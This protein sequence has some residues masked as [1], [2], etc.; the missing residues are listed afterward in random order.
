MWRYCAS[1]ADSHKNVYY[2]RLKDASSW[3]AW[4]NFMNHWQSSNNALN[5]HFYLYGSEED[6]ARDTNRW[7]FCN[8]NDGGVGF[9]RDCGPTGSVGAQWN[10]YSRSGYRP[11]VWWIAVVPHIAAPTL[12]IPTT[13]DSPLAAF[14]SRDFTVEM[15]LE[16]FGADIS[17]DGS[18]GC[19]FTRTLPNRPD[20][21]HGPAVFLY[22][23]GFVMF[24]MNNDNGQRAYCGGVLPD[25]HVRGTRHLTFI[26]KGLVLMILVDH[27]LVCQ[28]TIS[29]GDG[30]ALHQYADANLNFGRHTDLPNEQNLNVN[31]RN[32]RITEQNECSPCPAGT[33]KPLVGFLPCIPC[34][35]GTYRDAASAAT[36]C[37]PCPLNTHAPVE[38]L[39]A[40]L[41]ATDPCPSAGEYAND[42]GVCTPCPAN[43]EFSTANG[44][45]TNASAC[46][47]LAGYSGQLGGPCVPCNHYTYKDTVGS[48]PCTQCHDWEYSDKAA[49]ARSECSCKAGYTL[50]DDN[51]LGR[52]GTNC[53]LC[54]KGKFKAQNGPEPC[55]DCPAGTYSD[56]YPSTSCLDCPPGTTSWPGTHDRHGC[57]C[58]LRGHVLVDGVCQACP[59][60]H[61]CWGGNHS[62]PCPLNTTSPP[63]SHSIANCTPDFEN[64]EGI[65][66]GVTPFWAMQCE[67]T[68]PCPEAKP[69]ED[70]SGAGV[71]IHF[72]PGYGEFR[73]YNFSVTEPTRAKIAV[74]GGGGSGGGFRR[75]GGQG[76]GGAGDYLHD[77]LMLYPGVNYYFSVGAGGKGRA[78]AGQDVAKEDDGRPTLVYAND[79][80]LYYAAP[81]DAPLKNEDG[82]S[83]IANGGRW[84]GRGS[85]EGRG[86]PGRTMGI[87]G[88]PLPVSA[89]GGCGDDWADL[90][91]EG[92]G[93]DVFLDTWPLQPPVRTGGDGA[94]N[95]SVDGGDAR[96]LG[97][98]GGGLSWESASYIDYLRPGHGGD[99]AVILR[100]D[101][102]SC[103][104]GYG[105]PSC[106]KCSPPTQYSDVVG[107]GPCQNCPANS[108]V[109]PERTMSKALRNPMSQWPA[110]VTRTDCI[111]DLGHIGAN[112]TACE[113]CPANT[114]K[115]YFGP[116]NCRPCPENS[117]SEAGSD[118]CTCNSGFVPAT[119]PC[120]ICPMGKHATAEHTCVGCGAID[121]PDGR[122]PYCESTSISGDVECRQCTVPDDPLGL[123]AGFKTGSKRKLPK[124][125]FESGDTCE[126][127]CRSG[128]FG[129]LKKRKC[130]SV[131]AKVRLLDDD[132]ECQS[133][134]VGDGVTCK[135]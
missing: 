81:G 32:V 86:H 88:I 87:T 114:Y 123:V 115:D 84:T 105:G 74:I 78:L 107:Y 134:L 119:P 33:F 94:A 10:S 112:G 109:F 93:G 22:D 7:T 90:D 133:G 36:E 44:L 116:G 49:K 18:Y 132:C 69:L 38:G 122:Y 58:A 72:T 73:R 4:T 118:V 99:G 24:R 113:P 45:F 23:D 46:A 37:L 100:F 28:N 15:D 121:C 50:A 26:R 25:P 3:D 135:F 128:F 92:P 126:F 111:C 131:F 108:G 65:G 52:E 77:T 54:A 16:T 60:N 89:G 91:R 56:Y 8:Y 19:L 59:A 6:A 83:V 11:S 34:P 1:C 95:H 124:P 62:D 70:G 64:H 9:P 110:G 5:D 40:C 117:H 31:I 127:T 96:G 71:F 68:G 47:C 66:L 130:C 51:S 120:S 67:G 29:G 41:G 76:G 12:T 2:K 13:G 80:L 48:A 101:A 63:A 103:Q 129:N 39:T 30:I 35:I 53:D 20:P 43:S 42:E 79:E 27:Q 82:K 21:Y 104:R 85:Y 102:Y 106:E 17:P 97:A 98:G 14:G 75:H 61:Y 57:K 125:T 55:L